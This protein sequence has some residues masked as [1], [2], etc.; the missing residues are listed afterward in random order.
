M[1]IFISL[2]LS[3]IFL[4]L[5]AIHVYWVLGGK[6]GLA[7]AVPTNAGGQPLFRP[8]PVATLAV[9]GGLLLMGLTV[10][11]RGGLIQFDWLPDRVG[12]WSVWAI[13][14]IFLLRAVGD[15]RYVGFFKKERGAL[16]ARMDKRYFSPLC[17]AI[18]CL[19]V[20]LQFLT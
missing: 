17:L 16:F 6:W 9:A 19:A 14:A 13:A 4:A 12:E 10:L 7:A 1:A 5:S 2:L 3:A 20:L 8:G 18:G 15:F 11:V